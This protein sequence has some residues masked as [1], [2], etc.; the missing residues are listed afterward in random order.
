MA[1]FDFN[2]PFCDSFLC[3][4]ILNA[5][6]VILQ[7]TPHGWHLYSDLVFPFDKLIHTLREVGAD[8]AWIDIGQERGYFFLADKSEIDFPYPV[9]H[10]V[11]THGKKKAQNSK[12]T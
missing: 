10:M 4:M 3:S 8:A 7:K 5:N 11:L 2:F 1:D 9:E 6:Y 12:K